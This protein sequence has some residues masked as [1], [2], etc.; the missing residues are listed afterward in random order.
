MAKC[1]LRL[2]EDAALVERLTAQAYAECTRYAA[3]PVRKNWTALYHKLCNR[4]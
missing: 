3:D 2:L 1:A 4:P